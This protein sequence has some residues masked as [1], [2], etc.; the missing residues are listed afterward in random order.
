[1]GGVLTR[2]DP[3]GRRR[4]FPRGWRDG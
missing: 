3:P 4:L 2:D 1:M